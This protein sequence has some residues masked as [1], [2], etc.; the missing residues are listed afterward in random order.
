M[1][2]ITV[3]YMIEGLVQ[4]V[5]YRPFISLMAKKLNLTG[6]VRN[7]GG[8]VTIMVS[9]DSSR[10]KE[11][12]EK[13]ET[14]CPTGA[15][16]TKITEEEVSVN[17]NFEEFRIINS[18]EHGEVKLQQF[19]IIP[20]DI[21]TCPRCEAELFDES[22]KRFRHPFISCT[23]CGPRYS[24]IRQFPYDR[25]NTTMS[26]FDTC[27]ECNVEYT[28]PTDVRCHAQTIA[29]PDC[30]PKLSYGD[31]EQPDLCE[32]DNICIRQAV[33]DLKE[34]MILAIKGIGGFHLACDPANE[35]ALANL[36]TIKGRA[37]KPFAVMVDS[38]DTAKK[39]ADI[40]EKEE[41]E[42]LS[43]ARPIVL[44]EK[45]E[46][47]NVKKAI[48][49]GVTVNSP[50][51]G[52]MLPCNPIQMLIMKEMKQL[53]M[54][55]A[56]SSGDLMLTERRE[57]EGWF[58]YLEKTYPDIELR[59]LSNDRIIV[60]PLDDSIVRFV[61]G[62]RQIL[63]RSR[64]FVPLPINVDFQD[65][66]HAAGGDLKTSFAICKGGR[67]YVSQPFGDMGNYDAFPAY[68]AEEV[69]M[70][71]LL[72]AK[73]MPK[74]C[75][76]HPGYLTVQRLDADENAKSLKHVQHHKAHIAA[77]VAEHGIR[78]HI[79]GVAFDGT[80][81]GD[82]GNIWGGE[83][84]TCYHDEDSITFERE[85]QIKMVDIPGGD[86]SAKNAERTLYGYIRNSRLPEDYKCSLMKNVPWLYD[87][88]YNMI[89]LAMDMEL[90]SY[91]T[92]SMGRLFDAVS[93]LLGISSYNE[94]EGECPIEL[95][96][97]AISHMKKYAGM[98][99]DEIPSVDI[100]YMSTPVDMI[101]ALLEHLSEF[102]AKGKRSKKEQSTFVDMLSFS[103]IKGIANY[104]IG[105]YN[106]VCAV[107]EIDYKLVLSG[108]T[109]CNKILT[110]MIIKRI[111]D[112]GGRVYIS[113]E[114][115]PGDAGLCVGQALLACKLVE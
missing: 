85:S 93:A 92:S 64:G 50:F 66:I 65:E 88:K 26:M 5:G 9:G 42:M 84:F 48:A 83:I 68:I 33:K 102:F 94:Y 30:G 104:I 10:I 44:L 72:G 34:G 57:V 61:A 29:C 24:I 110:E 40:S 99:Y 91:M 62:R 67:A 21:A 89:S 87:E 31:V 27:D 78:G 60:T 111:E 52:M 59:I 54:T 2:N 1:D 53:V 71:R 76:K 79:L 36:R 109:F 38:I 28:T 15:V 112:I 81:Y 14:E 37:T 6:W 103:F 69:R 49:R 16:V 58:R 32:I 115:P 95:E 80:G 73:D 39:F 113:E 101:N 35:E 43:P 77:V 86:A 3:K 63:R 23:S 46:E 12:R 75:D 41:A 17:P 45:K 82:D 19:P 4:G 13:L 114:L 98:D 11:F 56:N 108:G 107:D 25:E 18:D 70:K 97:R 100:T 90:S 106:A 74:V 20:A 105:I 22:N 47:K 96:Y 55:S 8:I 7:Q 51:M